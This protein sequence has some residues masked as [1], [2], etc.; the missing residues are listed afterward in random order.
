LNLKGAGSSIPGPIR[1]GYGIVE[2]SRL[3]RGDHGAS[4]EFLNVYRSDGYDRLAM[5]RTQ[6]ARAG[7]DPAVLR[8]AVAESAPQIALIANAMDIDSLILG[9]LFQRDLEEILQRRTDP[10]LASAKTLS[11]RRGDDTVA[12]GAA[13]QLYWRTI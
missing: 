1:P 8:N 3:H 9:G 5:D 4:G 6:L 12:Y 7:E 2:R 11:A 13:A 10:T